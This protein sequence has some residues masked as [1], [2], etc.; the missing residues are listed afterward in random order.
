MI[1]PWPITGTMTGMNTALATLGALVTVGFLSTAGRAQQAPTAQSANAMADRVLQ[2]VVNGLW[3][4]ADHYWHD[5]DYNRIVGMGRLIVEIDPGYDEAYDVCA[6]L[7]WSLGDVSGADK[8]LEYGVKKSPRKGVFY[9]NLA[10]HLNRTKRYPDALAY[11]EKAIKL[12]GVD[13]AAWGTLGHL[14]TRAGR[15][16][17]AVDAWREVVKRFPE[18]PAGPKNLRAA[19]ERLKRGGK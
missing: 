11:M 17:E 2:K 18:F 14:Y 15:H 1:A 5:G 9:A 12:G 6:W 8:F 4:V 16:R 10:H 3:E 19:E 13:A 7:L